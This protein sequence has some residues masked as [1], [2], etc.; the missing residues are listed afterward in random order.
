MAAMS[1]EVGMAAG[2]A[3]VGPGMTVAVVTVAVGPRIA[4]HH[5][6]CPEC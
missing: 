5:E 4:S 1:L 3:A 6:R 2:M